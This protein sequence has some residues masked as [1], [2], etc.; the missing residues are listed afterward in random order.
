[1]PRVLTSQTFK[2]E[3]TMKKLVSLIVSLVIPALVMGGVMTNSAL[4]Q[5]TA[6][7]ATVKQTALLENDRVRVYEVS[8]KPGDENTSIA[9]SSPRIIR[10]LQGGSLQRT[11]ADG[12]KETIV[13]KDGEVKLQEPGQG[14]TTKNVGA[15]EV[16]L[17]VVMLK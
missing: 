3:K 17:Y 9:S 2:R 7:K 12:N 10:A 11:Y 15:T 6:A 5:E 13:W 1:M 8:F 4:A 14:Y 16:Q